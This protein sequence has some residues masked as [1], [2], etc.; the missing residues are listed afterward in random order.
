MRKTDH[1]GKERKSME[2]DREGNGE[3]QIKKDEIEEYG[4]KMKEGKREK[5]H[6]GGYGECRLGIK[7]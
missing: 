6:M 1:L 2:G 4:E 7:R 3:K 5:R